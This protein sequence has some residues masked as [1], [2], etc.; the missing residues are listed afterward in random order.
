MTVYSRLCTCQPLASLIKHSLIISAAMKKKG[1]PKAPKKVMK[2]AMEK[3]GAPI[4]RPACAVAREQ[5]RSLADSWH[6]PVG[7]AAE[8]YW[9]GHLVDILEAPLRSLKRKLGASSEIVVWLDCA[10]KCT[11][12]F[13]MHKLGDKLMEKIGMDIK[14]KL[15]SLIHI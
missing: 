13:A 2:A 3:K 9:A 10:G 14:F 7:G 12:M 4:K 5:P 11:E 15:L 1:A 6:K 8:P